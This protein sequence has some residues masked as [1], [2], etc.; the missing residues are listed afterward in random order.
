MT[1]I[2]VIASLSYHIFELIIF[3]IRYARVFMM[4]SST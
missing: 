3:K 1:L 2:I 4:V